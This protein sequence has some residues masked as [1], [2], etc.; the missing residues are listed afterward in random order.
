MTAD[1]STESAPT[2]PLIVDLDGTLTLSDTSFENFIVALNK[3]PLATFLTLAKLRKD[4][5]YVKRQLACLSTLDVKTIP[6]RPDLMDYL[7]A[8]KERG[9]E[10]HL[11][12]AADQSIAADV[13]DHTGI[14]TT[15][16]GSTPGLNLKGANKLAFLK[17]TFPQGFD[18]IGDSMADL[19]IWQETRVAHIAGNVPKMS[20]LAKDKNISVGR[21]FANATALGPRTWVKALRV[22]QWV[23]NALIV[24]PWGLAGD[25][26]PQ[27]LIKLIAIFFIFNIVA[28]STYLLNDLLDLRHDRAHPT[29]KR[30]PLASGTLPATTALLF[31][32]TA[33]PVSLL[34][35]AILSFPAAVYVV[36]YITLTLL[37]SFMLKKVAFVDAFCLATL[38]TLRIQIGVAALD[39]PIS[40]WLLAFSCLFFLS[41]GL[42]KRHLEVLKA[43][44]DAG[45][46]AAGRGY[47]PED[48]PIT[49]AFGVASGLSAII[50]MMLFIQE[51]AQFPAKYPSPKWLYVIAA[52]LLLWIMRVWQF[53]HRRQLDDD[54]IVFAIKD[55]TS[56][57]L[58]AV[59]GA[60]FLLAHTPW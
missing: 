36:C 43:G 9:R 51:Q 25:F 16:V 56:L 29:K 28:S 10:I 57:A 22:H 1:P 34:L 20:R 60:A 46:T 55:R 31:I 5:S 3:S 15:A 11:V 24:V 21:T 42:A 40:N 12:T 13:A 58:G 50:I 44:N 30:R 54:P 23:K 41:L 53:C 38:F 37:Y 47:R 48:W 35:I 4:T 52:C 26:E 19:T 45:Y 49:L 32:V 17:K 27:P 33:M 8:E 39:V 14:F 18:Y 59:T 7:K 6:Y 2:T